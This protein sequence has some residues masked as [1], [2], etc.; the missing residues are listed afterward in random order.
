MKRKERKGMEMGKGKEGKR[1]GKKV[2]L[3]CLGEKGGER[4][5]DESFPL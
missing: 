1:K 3:V 4:K 2:N 5:K